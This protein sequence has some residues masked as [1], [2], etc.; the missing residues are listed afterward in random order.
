M[1]F[2]FGKGFYFDACRNNIDFA[3]SNAEEG[4]E[5]PAF[6]EEYKNKFIVAMEDDLNNLSEYSKTRKPAIGGSYEEVVNNFITER[7][8]AKLRKMI[9]FKFKKHARYNLDNKRIKEIE[10]FLQERVR[11]L[12]NY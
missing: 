1:H 8:K 11:E 3:I 12:I 2:S 6:L 4:G 9:N 7:Q 5:V 10:K